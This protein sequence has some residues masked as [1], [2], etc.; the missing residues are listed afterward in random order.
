MIPPVQPVYDVQ[1]LLCFIH[2]FLT[3]YFWHPASPFLKECRPASDT[4]RDCACITGPFNTSLR[5]PGQIWW[6]INI[7]IPG[8]VPT[9]TRVYLTWQKG[10]A[11]LMRGRPQQKA[12]VSRWVCVLLRFNCLPTSSSCR[13]TVWKRVRS[14]TVDLN[15][16]SKR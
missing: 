5:S 13:G 2:F 12:S 3:T 14:F 1:R 9:Q 7:Y 10:S 15:K 11:E 16:K 6:Y 8:R 4:T